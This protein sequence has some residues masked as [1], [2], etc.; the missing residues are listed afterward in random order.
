MLTLAVQLFFL[1]T[2]ADASNRIV[3]L[4]GRQELIPC[5]EQHGVKAC[6]SSVICI[7]NDQ[8]CCSPVAGSNTFFPC[9]SGETCSNSGSSPECCDASGSCTT[10]IPFT[11]EGFIPTTSTVFQS[12]TAATVTANTTKVIQTVV[13][14]P[15]SNVTIATAVPS[16]FFTAAAAGRRPGRAVVYA[17]G[18][19][20][21]RAVAGNLGVI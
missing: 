19:L 14:T 20:L 6:G 3:P 9:F 8:I 15:S 10:I 21:A 2:L 5:V 13:T 1:L 16:Q 11:S 18:G 7:P 12:V 4:R 17:V